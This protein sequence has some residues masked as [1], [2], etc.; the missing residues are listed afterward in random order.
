MHADGVGTK[1]LVAEACHKYDTIGIDC[2][3]MNVNDVICVGA[4]PLALVNYLAL[5]KMRP[6][7]VKEVMVGLQKGAQEAGVAIVSGETAVM[8]DVIHGF[9]LAATVLGLVR[10]DRIITGARIR[11]GDMIFGMRSSGIHSNG[12]TLAREVT[13]STKIKPP[14]CDGAP[15]T[16]SH[17]RQASVTA[18]RIRRRS[19][20]H[21]SYHRRRLLEAQEAWSPSEGRF[22][23]GPFAKTAANLRRNTD[24]RAAVGP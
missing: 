6:Q 8:S 5:E 4:E 10:K 15:A 22:C 2:V 12:L 24:E 18:V 1:V 16:N 23:T 7:L 17:L 9:D 11:E 21:G 14:N 20:W 3:A 19:T 13:P